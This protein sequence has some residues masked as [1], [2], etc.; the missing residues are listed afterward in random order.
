MWSMVVEL[1]GAV[2]ELV[3]LAGVAVSLLPSTPSLY[4]GAP[5]GIGSPYQA[6]QSLMPGLLRA[7]LVMIGVGA[8][9]GAVSLALQI[10]G[11]SRLRLA[12][13]PRY[14]VGRTGALLMLAGF[15]LSM[16]LYAVMAVEVMPLLPY[17][18]SGSLPPQAVGPG[19]AAT[20]V[21]AAALGM[22]GALLAIIGLVMTWIGLW[23]LDEDYGGWMIRASI[24]LEIITVVAVVAAAAASPAGAGAALGVLV[25]FLLGFISYVL[26]LVGLHQVAERSRS[27]AAAH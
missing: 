12:D 20:A 1:V 3:V 23:R 17:L 4:S 18:A 14:G 19:I 9:F 6:I 11:W 8:A 26:A 25:G 15:V 27:L 16:A 24:I 5:P 10:L 22:V 13:R 21:A 2:A 7:Y